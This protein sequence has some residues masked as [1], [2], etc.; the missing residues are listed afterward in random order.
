MKALQT[1]LSAKTARSLAPGDQ[2]LISGR[3]FCGR[4]AALPRL[5][6]LIEQGQLEALGIELEG[7]VLFHSAVSPAGLGPTSSNKKEIED[8]MPVLARAGVRLHLGKGAI[9]EETV[10]ALNGSDSVYAVTPPLTALFGQN[11]RSQKILAFPQLG[12]EALH[13]LV[14]VD[15]PAIIAAA[16]GKSIYPEP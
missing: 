12:M 6:A 5:C 13:E 2:V 4:D 14:V 15:F 3:I 1:P 16:H 10:L 7:S 9:R 8:S 11:I